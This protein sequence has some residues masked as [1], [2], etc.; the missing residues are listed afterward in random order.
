MLKDYFMDIS[1]HF[2][3]YVINIRV[4]RN[5]VRITF[6]G[7]VIV[8]G[9]TSGFTIIMIILIMYFWR[10]WFIINAEYVPLVF[11]HK[12]PHITSSQ[13]KVRSHIY[14]DI[15]C[16]PLP[17]NSQYLKSWEVMSALTAFLTADLMYFGALHFAYLAWEL[18]NHS[19]LSHAGCMRPTTFQ[20]T[21]SISLGKH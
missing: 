12:W 13:I 4:S 11:L 7:F 21:C 1:H 6:L 20:I 15:T 5:T 8:N 19:S 2:Q 16:Y 17:L 18:N 9:M 3:Q 10:F 14:F